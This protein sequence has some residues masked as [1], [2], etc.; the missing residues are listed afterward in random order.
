M[1]LSSTS[2]MP[3]PSTSSGGPA[4]EASGYATRAPR[5]IALSPPALIFDLSVMGQRFCI[6][7]ESRDQIKPV[8]SS[9]ERARVEVGPL[10]ERFGEVPD[11]QQH[12]AVE[13]V[14]HDDRDAVAIRRLEELVL[15][16]Q[17]LVEVGEV[18]VRGALALAGFAR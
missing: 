2:G 7:P 9:E 16:P 4:T 1:H 8:A 11:H 5:T 6:G 13:A 14:V 12:R 17:D 15:D 18:L 3:S 10:A